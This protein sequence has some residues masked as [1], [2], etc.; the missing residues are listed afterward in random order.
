MRPMLAAEAVLGQV[1]YPIIAS[2]KLNGVRGLGHEVLLA[3]SL[4]KIPNQYCQKLFGNED[5]YGL[6]GELVVGPFDDEDVFVRST[7]GVMSNEGMPVVLWHVFD[8]WA[9]PYSF[10]ERIEALQ[11]HLAVLGHA[12]I[13]PVPHKVLNSDAELVA[14]ADE[15][16][17]LGYEGLV[18]R[19]PT[20][21]YKHGRSTALEGGFMRFCPWLT[22][23]STILAV[24]EGETNTNPA[25]TNE[26]GRTFRSSHQAGMVK[27]GTAGALLV[28]DLK[29]NLESRIPT[30]TDELCKWFWENRAEVVGKI[31]KY[32]FKPPVKKGGLPRFSQWIGFRSQLDMSE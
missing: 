23:E 30:T 1:K 17:S 24:I 21:M 12:Q 4:K 32:K 31:C 13:V 9:L 19:D 7:S 16:L 27:T 25:Q 10:A 2:P 6:D 5:C 18:L 22:S 26:L 11:E 3:R 8:A 20:A 28:R 29:T 15:C 14:F